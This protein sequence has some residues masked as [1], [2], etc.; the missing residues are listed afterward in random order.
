[1][2]LANDPAFP[3]DQFQALVARLEAGTILVMFCVIRFWAL[4]SFAR[5]SGIASLSDWKKQFEEMDMQLTKVTHSDLSR[6]ATQTEDGTSLLF[7]A[8]ALDALRMMAIAIET[9]LEPLSIGKEYVCF[10]ET[11]S[12]ESLEKLLKDISPSNSYYHIKGE[13][14]EERRS[15]IQVGFLEFIDKQKRTP[16]G[17]WKDIPHTVLADHRP[18]PHPEWDHKAREF[19]TREIEDALKSD[20]PILDGRVENA[21]LQVRTAL[22]DKYKSLSPQITFKTTGE[23]VKPRNLD[24]EKITPEKQHELGGPLNPE[25]L[26]NARQTRTK[27]VAL[28][29]HIKKSDPRLFWALMKNRTKNGVNKTK[30]AR[31]L[32]ISRQALGERIEKLVTKVAIELGKGRQY[33]EK[34]IKEI[35]D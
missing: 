9:R 23:T 11:E 28:T 34:M 21:T 16:V 29:D 15:D 31:D 35:L 8:T 24:L 30:A 17:N 14:P 27:Q 26:F 18:A 25:I 19:L 1:L 4:D 3:E 32:G 5:L 7:L 33:L 2:K 6:L 20:L 12:E 22:R 13:R 10:R